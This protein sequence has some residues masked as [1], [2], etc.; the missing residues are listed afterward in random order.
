MRDKKEIAKADVIIR[1]LYNWG[2][3]SVWAIIS[4][5]ACGP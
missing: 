4:I 3:F 5:T 1:K 2:P